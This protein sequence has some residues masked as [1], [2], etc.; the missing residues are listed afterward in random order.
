MLL[1][2]VIKKL[3]R[4]ITKNIDFWNE[5]KDGASFADQLLHIGACKDSYV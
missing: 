3:K 2:S 1:V 4:K 5:D